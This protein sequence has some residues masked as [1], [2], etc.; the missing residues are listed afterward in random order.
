[1]TSTPAAPDR[2]TTVRLPKPSLEGGLTVGVAL[3]LRRSMREFASGSLLLAAAG[4]LLWAAQGVSGGGLRTTPSAGATYPLEVYLV[5]AEVTGLIPGV[6]RYLPAS[7]GLAAVI[8]GDCRTAI[9]AAAAD[10]AWIAKAP[11]DLVIASEKARTAAQY[12]RMAER[13]VAM[14]AGCAAQNVALTAV[15]LGLATVIV[16]AFDPARLAVAAGLPH[17]HE[18]LCLMPVGRQWQTP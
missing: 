9:S 15:A 13:Y 10:Q 12:G 17:A 16:G 11:A 8:R 2:T 5:A 14:E 7:H 1:M 4:D 18:P 3:R 6:Y